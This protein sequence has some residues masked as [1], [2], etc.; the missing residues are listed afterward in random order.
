MTL[1]SRHMIRC[2][3]TS[4]Q[5]FTVDAHTGL[6][7]DMNSEHHGDHRSSK[8]D[9]ANCLWICGTTGRRRTNAVA[10]SSVVPGYRS[11]APAVKSTMDGT[12]LEPRGA[13]TTTI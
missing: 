6:H 5:A 12:F 3:W 2:S 10:V 13:K 8:F 1:S 9:S 4:G 7:C 11:S